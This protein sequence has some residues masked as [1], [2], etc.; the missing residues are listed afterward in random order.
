MSHKEITAHIR[1]RIKH[2][3]IKARVRLYEACGSRFIQIAGITP[4]AEFTDEQQRE[5]RIIAQVNGLTLSRG[6]PIDIEQM[7]NPKQFDF[8]VK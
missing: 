7:T 8:V 3:G 6:M 5:I 4:D 1:G 2:A